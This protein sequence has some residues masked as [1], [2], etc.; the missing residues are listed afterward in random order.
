MSEAELLELVL[1][2]CER[3]SLWAYHVPNLA[4]SRIHLIPSAKGFPDLVIFGAG[5]VIFR[6]LKSSRSNARSYEQKAW[7]S[8]LLNGG[9]DYDVWYPDDWRSGEISSVLAKLAVRST[10]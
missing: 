3:R 9:L 6:E 5:G 2:E 1:G 7:G 4:R 10:A 8:G